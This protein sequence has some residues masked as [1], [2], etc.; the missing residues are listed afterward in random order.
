MDVS[1]TAPNC[2]GA[3]VL[4]YRLR[5]FKVAGGVSK[6]QATLKASK[7]VQR[8]PGLVP[9]TDYA[10]QVEVRGFWWCAGAVWE[11]L[12]GVGKEGRER[13]REARRRKEGRERETER[14]WGKANIAP[15]HASLI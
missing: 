12:R 4:D 7:A 14:R 2:R 10:V 3:P 11:R 1:W 6:E 15:L 9:D 5:L 8:L 13:N